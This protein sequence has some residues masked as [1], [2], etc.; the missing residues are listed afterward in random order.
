MVFKLKLVNEE[1]IHIIVY[2]VKSNPFEFINL[3]QKL[4]LSYQNE[5]YDKCAMKSV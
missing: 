3:F 4:M 2:L 1:G 5:Q